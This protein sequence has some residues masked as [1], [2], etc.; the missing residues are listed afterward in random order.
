MPSTRI[1]GVS[2]IQAQELRERYVMHCEKRMVCCKRGDLPNILQ[3][4]LGEQICD[5]QEHV[6]AKVSCADKA[7]GTVPTPRSAELNGPLSTT[8]SV[9]GKLQEENVKQARQGK[10]ERRKG[11]KGLLRAIGNRRN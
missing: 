2:K 9:K 7:P 10:E 4:K 1:K 8:R 3:L 5:Q 11:M 6:F